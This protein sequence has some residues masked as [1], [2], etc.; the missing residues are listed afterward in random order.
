M[1]RNLK[2]LGLAL[3]AAMALGAIGA[4]AASA[5]VEH[6]FNSDAEDTVLTGKNESFGTGNSRDVFQATPGLTVECDATFGGTVGKKVEDTVTV[7]PKYES[8]G[9]GVTVHTDGCNY[10]FGSDTT[11]SAH[12]SSSEHASVSLECEAGHEIEITRPGCNIAFNQFHSTTEVNQGLHGVRYTNLPEHSGGDAITVD[13]TVSTIKYLVTSGSF[14]GLAGHAAGT[15]S[16]GSYDGLAEVTGF[17]AGT[18][19][20]SETSSTTKGFTW[21]HGPQTNISISTPT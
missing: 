12:S 1:I 3:V 21:H 15:Y 8:C 14:C 6:S 5:V 16:N 11:T 13:A 20:E 4:Q 18:R 9:G 7:H 10:I 17:A 19:T 2:A